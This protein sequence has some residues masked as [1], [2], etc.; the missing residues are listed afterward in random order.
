MA[1]GNK[2]FLIRKYFYLTQSQRQRMKKVLERSKR[3]TS[4]LEMLA[5]RLELETKVKRRVA[6]VGA[7][8]V[9]T[10]LRMELFQ[11]LLKMLADLAWLCTTSSSTVRPS[12]CAVSTSSRSSSGPP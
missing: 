10:N 9:I 4:R 12:P 5:S 7:F 3:L 11:A 2:Y 8:S 1:A 6:R